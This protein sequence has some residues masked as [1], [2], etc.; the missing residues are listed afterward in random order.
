MTTYTARDLLDLGCPQGP[1][2][3][4]VLAIV[5]ATPHTQA[6]VQAVVAEQKPA[7][8]LP[9]HDEP[10]PCQWNITASNEAEEANVAAVRAT[11][12]RVLRTPCVI[13]GAV[14]PDAC[15]AG[16]LGTIPVG[17]V[18]ATRDAICPG[19]HSAD[20]CCSLMASVIVGAT[21]AEVLEA[22]NAVT[23]FGPGGRVKGKQLPPGDLALFDQIDA[24]QHQGV[25]ALA[26]THLGTQGDGNHFLYVGRLESTGQTVMVTHHGSR[27]PGARLYRSGMATAERYRKK[28]SPATAKQNAWIPYDSDEGRAYWLA[29]QTIRAWTRANHEVIHEHAIEKANGQV[30]DRLWNEHNFV[31]REEDG[32][33]SIFWHAKGATPI[34]NAFLPDTDG[35]QIVPLNMAEPILFVKGERNARNRG[36]A[37]HGAG[38]NMSRTRHKAAL[39]GRTDAEVFAEETAGLDVRF[40]MGQTDISELPSAY[41]NAASVLAD[42][43]AFDLADVVDRVLPYG[44]IMAGDWERDAPWK[45]ARAA[46]RAAR[47]KR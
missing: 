8:T 7:P 9:L 33:G 39:A 35:R 19:M 12:N 16:P 32:A 42:M 28:L 27:G 37:P 26:R 46:K 2:I 15:P 3:P 40:W 36:F 30:A 17:G 45:K 18:I 22:A 44:S 29:L 23:H 5:N 20:I 25:T 10:A 24:L 11:M 41:K 38:R 47:Q 13:E 6:Q 4:R 21:P 14:M 31:F 1:E 34:H 43:R